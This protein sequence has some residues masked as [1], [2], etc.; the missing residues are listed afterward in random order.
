ML[1][2]KKEKEKNDALSRLI[3]D[4]VSFIFTFQKKK[5]KKKNFVN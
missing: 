5:K 2:H 4:F 3:Y 1:Y